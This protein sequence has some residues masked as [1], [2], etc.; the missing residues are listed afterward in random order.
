MALKCAIENELHGWILQELLQLCVLLFAMLLKQITMMFSL[1][2]RVPFFNWLY[3]S[4]FYTLSRLGVPFFLMITGALMLNREY[5]AKSFYKR[6]LIP[7]LLTTQ[8]WT[9]INFL[10]NQI[11]HHYDYSFKDFIYTLFFF[12]SSPFPHMWYMPMILG[13]YLIIPFLARAVKSTPFSEASIPLCLGLVAFSII[14]FFNVFAGEVFP[15]IPDIYLALDVTF[16]GGLYGILMVFGH[17][18]VNEQILKKFPIWSLLLVFFASLTLNIVC[19]RYFYNNQ[20]FHSVIFGW[21]TSP[22]IIIMALCL[23]EVLRRFPIKIN[24]SLALISK[25]SFAIYLTHY[26]IILIA[27]DVSNRIPAFL[28]LNIVA[29]TFIYFVISFGIPLIFILICDKLPFKR[30]KKLFLY[31]K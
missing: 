30:L 27:I 3:E 9:V 11:V 16:L 22:F 28:K 19:S 7:L 15:N 5:D 26:L 24:K 10:F 21:Y 23:F 13:M 1:E 17:Y 6:T 4:F 31:M 2:L 29:K 8:I 14:P 25:G 18:I 20:L 12:K